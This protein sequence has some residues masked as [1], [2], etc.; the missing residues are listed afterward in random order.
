MSGSSATP[1]CAA[2]RA[3]CTRDRA[4]TRCEGSSRKPWCRR[5]CRGLPGPRCRQSAKL[6]DLVLG[7]GQRVGALH[8][9]RHDVGPLALGAVDRLEGVHRFEVDRVDVE[10]LA[11][12]VGG[13][14]LL[15]EDFAVGLAE[16][17]ERGLELVGP[18]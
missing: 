17:A 15:T 4:S 18:R 6:A 3:C 11:P 12:R 10:E 14:E 5:P 13:F 16:L 1:R 8:L 9:D 7:L 2:A